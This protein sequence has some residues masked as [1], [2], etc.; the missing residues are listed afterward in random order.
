MEIRRRGYGMT[1]LERWCRISTRLLVF[2]AFVPVFAFGQGV[3]TALVRVYVTDPSGASIPA[4][5]VTITNDGTGVDFTCTTDQSGSC[6]FNTLKP[7]S[8]TAKVMASNFKVDVREHI[9][10]HVGQAVDLNF[11]LQIG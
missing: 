3:D 9:V 2:L 8:Y 10:L 6:R 11:A 4:A 5:T 1:G 7:A